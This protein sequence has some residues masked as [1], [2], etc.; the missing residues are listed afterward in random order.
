M[1]SE[2]EKVSIYVKA[3]ECV[4]VWI[5][6]QTRQPQFII[7]MF[8]IMLLCHLENTKPASAS[9]YVC[10]FSAATLAPPSSN[11]VLV[12]M[13][14]WSVIISGTG[15]PTQCEEPPQR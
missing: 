6:T 13:F 4:S 9:I 15:F 14:V 2:L 7:S 12:G 5:N 11:L 3:S 1:F 10:A 8:A